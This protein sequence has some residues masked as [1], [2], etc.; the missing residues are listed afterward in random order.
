MTALHRRGQRVD[1]CE[2]GLGP[3]A[4]SAWLPR[5]PLCSPAV[6]SF[7]P[8]CPRPRAPPAQGWGAG[9]P[10]LAGAA[11]HRRLWRAGGKVHSRGTALLPTWQHEVSPLELPVLRARF[12]E[13]E[14]LGDV[15]GFVASH[16]CHARGPSSTSGGLVTH[17]QRVLLRQTPRD[18]EGQSREL[19]RGAARSPRAC[20]AG[21]AWSLLPGMSCACAGGGQRALGPLSVSQR[22]LKKLLLQ[23]RLCCRVVGSEDKASLWDTGCV[24][25]TLHG[26]RH[27]RPPPI[28]QEAGAADA[29]S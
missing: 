25:D 10:G 18:W 14:V 27:P 11:L 16:F 24:P 3:R 12:L 22:R 6:L 8:L 9:N 26:P 19:Q 1:V 7:P 21:R 2:G 15:V 28:P 29:P 5:Q 23:P 17:T 20:P 13:H 4:Q